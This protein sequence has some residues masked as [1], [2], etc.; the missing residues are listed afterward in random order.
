MVHNRAAVPPNRWYLTIPN[1]DPIPEGP[2][3]IV[4]FQA[5]DV[6]VF[7]PGEYEMG[8]GAIMNVK[9]ALWRVFNN[10]D[11]AH[12]AFDDALADDVVDVV[13]NDEW[14]SD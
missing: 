12:R 13:V 6:G 7:G 4:L 10:I 3:W 11:V 1:A 8:A 9:G 5:A 2:R 14:E